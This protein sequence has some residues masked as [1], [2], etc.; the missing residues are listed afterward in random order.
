MNMSTYREQLKSMCGKR[1]RIRKK[2]EYKE[3]L[4][5]RMKYNNPMFDPEVRKKVSE[6]LKGNKNA[7]KE[8]DLLTGRGKV[9]KD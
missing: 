1:E 9:K 5:H 4:I 6:K 8:K 2:K 3:K 7:C